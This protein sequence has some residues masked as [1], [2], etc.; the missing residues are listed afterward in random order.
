VDKKAKTNIRAAASSRVARQGDVA[1][2]LQG[3][4]PCRTGLLRQLRFLA[5]TA[6]LAKIESFLT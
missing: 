4:K 2:H 5:M 1:I 3:I 6:F